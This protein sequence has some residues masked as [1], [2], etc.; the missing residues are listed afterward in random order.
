MFSLNGS[1]V[2][3]AGGRTGRIVSAS[4][5]QINLA[6]MQ[7][8]LIAEECTLERTA[9]AEDLQILTLKE[10][11]L[12]LEVVAGVTAPVA[13]SPFMSLIEDLQ[14]L[15][16]DKPSI[17]KVGKV[18]L[19]K[20][21]LASKLKAKI[22]AKTKLKAAKGKAKLKAKVAKVKTSSGEPKKFRAKAKQFGKQAHSPFKRHQHNG[23]AEGG[24]H[25]SREVDRT[26]RWHCKK[27][28]PYKQTCKKLKKDASGRLRINKQALPKEITIKPDYKKRYN[29]KYKAWAAKQGWHSHNFAA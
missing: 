27:S 14:R 11:W 22:K 15:T 19:S 18:K 7:K 4:E 5:S 24:D 3:D 16:K 9:L 23:P 2:R 13:P 8:G 6:W 12:P 10:G 29:H 25:G 20:R 28:A 21:Q 26:T 17:K 1:S